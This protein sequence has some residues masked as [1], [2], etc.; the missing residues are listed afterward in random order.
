VGVPENFSPGGSMPRT[1]IH[2][3]F[4]SVNAG[5]AA[6]SVSFDVTA[7]VRTWLGPQGQNNGV[8]LS[9]Q[10]FKGEGFSFDDIPVPE[11]QECMT[12]FSNAKLLVT[13]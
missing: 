12:H 7:M 4:L 13:Y 2:S 5:A 6:T 1:I 11:N 3:D 10:T 8:V 9:P